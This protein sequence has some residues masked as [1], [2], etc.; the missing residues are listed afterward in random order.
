MD[1]FYSQNLSD[2]V[3]YQTPT[4]QYNRQQPDDSTTSNS[5]GP[6][7]SNNTPNEA[8]KT[9][10]PRKCSVRGCMTVMPMDTANKMCEAC[11]QRHRV[12][13]TTKRL[14]RK[15]EKDAINQ[16]SAALLLTEQPACRSV[17]V[18]ETRA[19]DGDKKSGR[20]IANDNDPQKQSAVVC[21]LDA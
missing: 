14:K 15:M 12:Y 3:S 5:A 1:G 2:A 6:L 13:A 9:K 20:D 7:T 10:T 18:E 17:W 8:N 11:R 16:Q 19:E 21:H 4:T